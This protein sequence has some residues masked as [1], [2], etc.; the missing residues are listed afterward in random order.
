M[1][2][3]L[4]CFSYNNLHQ[5]YRSS[6]VEICKRYVSYFHT[7]HSMIYSTPTVRRSR[8]VPTLCPKIFLSFVD[9]TTE[10]HETILLK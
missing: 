4:G 5:H 7:E 1:H 10:Y 3:N 8:V 9:D 6:F 2:R